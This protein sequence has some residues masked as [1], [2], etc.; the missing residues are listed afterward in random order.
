MSNANKWDP[1]YNHIP[2]GSD[3]KPYGNTRAY[4]LGAAWLERCP[5]VEDWG[6]GLGYM[7]N[8]IPKA[9][10][11]GIDGT[12]SPFADV[13]ADLV[14][15]RS[16]VSGIYMRGVIEHDYQWRKILEN[17]VASFKDRMCLVLFTPM[18]NVP[19]QIAYND[20][21]GVPDL[22]F[23]PHDLTPVFDE[24]LVKVASVEY[25]KSDTAY[26]GETIFYLEK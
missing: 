20:E 18:S 6:C 9:R 26:G 8:F 13:L 2:Q 1:W 16:A 12:R 11:K 7:R 10:Y 15:Y 17:A 3:P 22:C 14:E 24:Q 5:L 19:R 21:I 25:I 23:A 4:Q